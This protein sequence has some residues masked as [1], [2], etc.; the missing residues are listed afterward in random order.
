MDARSPQTST[1]PSADRGCAVLD[2][3][4]FARYPN[5]ALI[6]PK[7]SSVYAKKLRSAVRAS[8]NALTSRF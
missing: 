1:R 5:P 8:L 7:L 2:G 3:R 4:G 6:E